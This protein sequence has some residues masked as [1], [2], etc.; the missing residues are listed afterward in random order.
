MDTEATIWFEN[1]RVMDPVLK[2]GVLKVQQ[3]EA[4][5][6][7]LRMLSAEFFNYTQI[8]LFLKRHRFGKCPHLIFLYTIGHNNISWRPHDIPIPKKSRPQG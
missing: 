5:I 8:I 1:W 4:H 2:T 6:T 7:G 3:A